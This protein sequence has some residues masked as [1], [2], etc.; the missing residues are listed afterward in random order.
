MAADIP[1]AAAEQRADQPSSPLPAACESAENNNHTATAPT[2]ASPPHSQ[3]G[4]PADAPSGLSSPPP[5]DP[6]SPRGVA[7]HLKHRL[8][9]KADSVKE[10]KPAGG[11][12]AT[13]LPDFPAGYT[14]KITIHSAANLPRGDFAT[15]SSDP[16]V[17]AT[18]TADVPRRHKEDPVL[19][20]RTRTLR[21]T[22][23][24]EWE[25]EW[26]V[27]NVPRTGFKLKC[28]IY[29]EDYPDNDD[30]LGNVTYIA[31]RVDE[32]WEGVARRTFQAKKR[33]GSKRAY[34]VKAV[35]SAFTK[36]GSITPRLTLSVE[37]LGRSEGPGAQMYTVGPTSFVQ[38]FS[39]MIGR[40]TGTKVNRDEVKDE[41]PEGEGTKEG[42]KSQDSDKNKESDDRQTKK[43]DFQACEMQLQGPVP[44]RL[45]HR[46]VE[47]S[48]FV[49]PMFS[50]RGL[51]GTILNKVLHKQ[52]RRVYNFDE[53]TKYGTFAPCSTEA[54][55]QFLRLAHF[56]EGG[57]IF[58]YVLTLDGLFRFTETG[59]EFG[60]DM[61]SK[62]TMHSDVATYIAF[63]GEF[64]IRRRRRTKRSDDGVDDDE[65]ATAAKDPDLNGTQPPDNKPPASPSPP[66]SDPRM[67]QLVI[68]NDSGTYRPDKSCLPGLEAFLSRN[69]PGL[70]VTALHWE[71]EH[72]KAMK[73]AQHEAK[74]KQGGGRVRMVLNRSPTS[75]SFSSSDESRLSDM[76]YGDDDD[77]GMTHARKTKKELAWDVLE[78][79]SRIR[80]TLGVGG[81]GGS[82]NSSSSSSAKKHGAVAPPE[83]AA[84][85]TK[86]W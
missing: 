14:V 68:D 76:D 12:D 44:P 25:Q 18:L 54:A 20:F 73:A 43:Y 2:P 86:S 16:F 36:N 55:L 79:P 39:P 23:E 45:Y 59:K 85:E 49:A 8:N 84:V 6:S 51:R 56:D 71:D 78:D 4:H 57:R 26:V 82:S 11:F 77:D 15:A 37:V 46:Y 66:P 50:S 62:H 17:H 48:R 32:D 35:E 5:Q 52:H 34:L 67:Y 42:K 3:N 69:F 47:F 19:T 61:L 28:R 72:L 70:S 29:D 60:I 40:L 41:Q 58:T 75:S 22:T 10:K 7:L 21:R 31:R 1:A 24:P 83:V 80:E 81:G 74:K 13:P 27:A 63:S 65:A 38:H 33:V 30:R 53:T 9:E 64:F